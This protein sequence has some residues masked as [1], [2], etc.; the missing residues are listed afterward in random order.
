MIKIFHKIKTKLIPFALSLLG[1]FVLCCAPA[2]SQVNCSNLTRWSNTNPPVNQ[3][4]IFCGEWKNN[5]AKGFHSRPAG[6][7]P[8]TVENFNITQSANAQGVYGATWS[9]A[10]YGNNTKFSTMFP[11]SC[12]KNQVLN[13]IIYAANNQVNCPSN[14][15]SW[16]WCGLN[17]P[18]G[19]AANYCNGDDE[20]LFTI[21]GASFNDGKVN[22][23]F[24]LR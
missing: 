24:P 2:Q 19:N 17:A 21:A 15:P 22:T 9:Y 1:A 18:T 3:P 10:G 8:N 7:N 12:T 16:A 4:H 11:D 23:A 20:N 14:A 5:R 6:V 13:S